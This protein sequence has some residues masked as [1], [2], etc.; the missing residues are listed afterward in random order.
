MI[1]YC[2]TFIT[3]TSNYVKEREKLYNE[4][5]Q[6]IFMRAIQNSPACLKYSVPNTVIIID[7]SAYLPF[8]TYFTNL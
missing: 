3:F 7:C 2:N 5:D 4:T 1:E 8:K 6:I